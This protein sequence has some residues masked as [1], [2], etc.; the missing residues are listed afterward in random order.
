M[1]YIIKVVKVILN[2][3][4]LPFKLLKTKKQ[5]TLISR[6]SN[7]KTTDFK[8]LEEELIKE[9]PDYKIV[10]LCKT[11]DNKLAYIFHMI[12]Q[13]YHISRSKIVILDSYCILVSMLKHKKNL[14]VIQIWHALG[15][16]KKAGYAILDKEEGR[17]KEI[18]IASN[19]HKNYDYILTSSKN[20]IKS[21]SEVFNYD[22]SKVHSVPLP[23][24]DLIKSTKYIGETKNK[25]LKKYKELNK[26]SNIL[27]APT[28][29]KDEKLL[30]VKLNELCSAIDYKKYNLIVKLHPLS[31]IQV[32]NNNVIIDKEFSTTDM[33]TVADY[34]IS[35][36]SSIIYEAGIMNKKLIFYAFDLDSYS[37]NRSFF[38]NYNKELPGPIIKEAKEIIKFIRNDDYSNYDNNL[39]KKYVDCNIDNYTN[40][41]V[42][43]IKEILPKETRNDK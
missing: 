5:I 43:F 33:M 16:M 24:I 39:I 38:I 2:I 30:Q 19:M 1:K 23:R 14:K 26:K 13:M 8:L 7:D 22:K 40:N 27:Y 25:I 17:N 9:L 41:M 28:F 4:Y 20:C 32:N 10:V 3:I 29:R 18:A 12:K 42:K 34:V 11:M 21:I 35:D 37:V 31:K 36:Y 6:L 15:L